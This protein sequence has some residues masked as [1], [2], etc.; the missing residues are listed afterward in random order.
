[1]YSDDELSVIEF[2]EKVE[3]LLKLKLFKEVITDEYMHK[4]VLSKGLA[5]DGDT[6]GLEAVTHLVSWL[7]QKIDDAINIKNSKQG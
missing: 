6:T 7:Q 3:D 1:M 5:F 2:G 4:T